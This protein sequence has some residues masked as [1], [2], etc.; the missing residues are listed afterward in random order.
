MQV[1]INTDSVLWD[2]DK[3]FA[4]MANPSPDAPGFDVNTLVFVDRH[5]RGLRE[6]TLGECASVPLQD[7]RTSV[8]VEPPARK[9]YVDTSRSSRN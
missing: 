8:D 9:L 2:T 4:P 7:L 3:H 1:N 5:L 6:G